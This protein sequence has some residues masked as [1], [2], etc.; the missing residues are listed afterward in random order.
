MTPNRARKSPKMLT[1]CA[2]QSRRKGFWRNMSFNEKGVAGV[3]MP[4]DSME[5]SAA[6]SRLRA[7]VARHCFSLR[8]FLRP[9]TAFVMARNDLQAVQPVCAW[10]LNHE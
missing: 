6:L 8:N 3:A 5:K 2:I 10:G 9:F 4:Q 1:N 7:S